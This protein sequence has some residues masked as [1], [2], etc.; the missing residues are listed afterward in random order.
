MIVEIH[1]NLKADQIKF[2]RCY[3][4]DHIEW[5]GYKLDCKDGKHGLKIRDMEKRE[6]MICRDRIYEGEVLAKI[7]V[8][9]GKM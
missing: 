6:S 7:K 5:Q 4:H 9:G 3:I 8:E 1:I 2:D